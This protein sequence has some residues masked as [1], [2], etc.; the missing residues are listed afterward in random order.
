MPLDGD[1]ILGLCTMLYQLR[2]DL[3]SLVF[4]HANDFGGMSCNVE[5]LQI[6]VYE[7]RSTAV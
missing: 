5:S 6:M 2:E 1:G 4:G 3:Q 7:R